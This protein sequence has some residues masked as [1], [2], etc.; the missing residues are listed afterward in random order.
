MDSKGT[1]GDF[2]LFGELYGAQVK[3]IS[4]PTERAAALKARMEKLVAVDPNDL[5][6]L[7]LATKAERVAYYE[8]KRLAQKGEKP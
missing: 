8:A 6:W 1:I 2:K 3:D 7:A 5:S 4:D